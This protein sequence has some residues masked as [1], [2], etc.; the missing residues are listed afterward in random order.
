MGG[1][2]TVGLRGSWCLGWF[3]WVFWGC[4]SVGAWGGFAWVLRF[5]VGLV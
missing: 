5:S 2:L 1:V 3:A 4:A